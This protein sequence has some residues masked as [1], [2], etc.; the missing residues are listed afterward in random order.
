MG[1]D[2]RFFG[3]G[4]F[5]FDGASALCF[6]LVAFLLVVLAIAA[7]SKIPPQRN[8]HLGRSVL[9]EPLKVFQI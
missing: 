8:A 7:P 6:A 1:R 4:A 9:M 5:S 2:D 3:A